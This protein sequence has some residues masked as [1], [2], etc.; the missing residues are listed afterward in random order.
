MTSSRFSSD[1]FSAHVKN[2]LQRSKV[3]GNEE[4]TL[5]MQLRERERWRRQADRG[6]DEQI[7]R[8]L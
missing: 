7:L 4:A 8:S 1:S 5:A 3:G 6:G 2:R